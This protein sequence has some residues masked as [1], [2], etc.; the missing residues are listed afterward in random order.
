MRYSL[1]SLFLLVA[2]VAVVLGGRIEYLRR[3][4]AFHEQMAQRHAD[5]IENEGG[6]ASLSFMLTVHGLQAAGGPSSGCFVNNDHRLYVRHRDLASECRRA[7][8]RPWTTIR[9]LPENYE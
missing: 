1:R 7:M 5:L 3:W 8:Y 2:L 4:A 9:E 6:K